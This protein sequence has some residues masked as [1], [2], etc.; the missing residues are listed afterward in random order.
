MLA[1]DDE[2]PDILYVDAKCGSCQWSHR[3]SAGAWEVQTAGDWEGYCLGCGGKTLVL[4][5]HYDTGEKVE[6]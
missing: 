1:H 2:R 4:D 6:D 3:Y 5:F